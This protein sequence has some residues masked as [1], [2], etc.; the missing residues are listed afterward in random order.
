LLSAQK[1]G[2]RFFVLN[3]V[4]ARSIRAPVIMCKVASRA[5][6]FALVERSTFRKIGDRT[7]R[8]RARFP[9]RQAAHFRASLSR[10]EFPQRPASAQF[11]QSLW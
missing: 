5:S 4:E 9:R 10:G 11:A 8:I 1:K 3:S 7:R 2:E 6:L